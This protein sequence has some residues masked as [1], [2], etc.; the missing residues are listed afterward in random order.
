MDL[1]ARGGAA[2]RGAGGH[3]DEAAGASPVQ[4]RGRLRRAGAIATTQ[5]PSSVPTQQEEREER[6]HGSFLLPPRG[7][8]RS[9]F[10]LEFILDG[11][12]TSS[13]RGSPWLI[14][15]DWFVLSSEISMRTIL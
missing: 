3:R 11:N 10:C 15:K 13:S 7:K 12:T 5:D 1:R 4:A 8:K 6:P 9:F 14:A 2:A